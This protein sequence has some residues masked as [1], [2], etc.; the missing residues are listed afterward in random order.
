V[1]GEHHR[2]LAVEGKEKNHG[3]LGK[4]YD[5]RRGKGVCY[6]RGFSG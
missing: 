5:D 1:A 6:Y 4:E 3:R 2:L